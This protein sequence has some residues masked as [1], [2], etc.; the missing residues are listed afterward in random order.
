MR[1]PHA[2]KAQATQWPPRGPA[3]VLVV[4]DRQLLVELIKLTLNHT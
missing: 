3:R 1:P 4:L 2:V